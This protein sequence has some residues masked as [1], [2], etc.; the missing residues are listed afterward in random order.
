MRGGEQP[1]VAFIDLDHL[2]VVNDGL[3]H[4]AGD[5]VIIAAARTP[6]RRGR[7][8]RRRR[9]LRRRR[10]H[11][12]GARPAPPA[13]RISATAAWQ[14]SPNPSPSGAGM[15][16]C[17]P[18]SAWSPSTVRPARVRCCATPMPRCTRRSGPA[19]AGGCGSSR[20]PVTR[21][22]SAAPRAAAA[23]GGGAGERGR[24]AAA[25]RALRRLALLGV[26]VL[27][28]WRPEGP[29][30]GCR[31]PTSSRSRRRSG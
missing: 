19:V 20:R 11:H 26:E 31:R 9:A 1:I 18:A 14:R 4:E 10:V 2:K 15:A 28:R 3:G 6:A 5:Q 8:R 17:R 13:P 22:A 12:R 27:A 21:C 23:R 29:A 24:L 7:S 30:S 16:A 25:D